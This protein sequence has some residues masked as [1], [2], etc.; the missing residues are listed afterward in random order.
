MKGTLNVS[1]HKLTIAQLCIS[2]VRHTKSHY[3]RNGRITSEV[4]NIQTALRP[5]VK[6]HGKCLESEFGPI[7]LKQVRDGMVANGIVRKSVNRG[8]GRINRMFRWGVENEMVSTK[9]LAAINSVPG[10]RYGLS[11]FRAVQSQDAH[12]SVKSINWTHHRRMTVDSL[13]TFGPLTYGRQ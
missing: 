11:G 7:K 5:L 6:I 12:T 9:V 3:V 2:C 1:Y 10:L 4:S 13:P 8:I